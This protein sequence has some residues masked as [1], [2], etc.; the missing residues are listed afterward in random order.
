MIFDTLDNIGRYA[1]A[2]P[3]IL[4][5][6]PLIEQAAKGAELPIGRIEISGDTYANVMTYKPKSREEGK[7]ETHR[8]YFDIQIV[9]S[10]EERFFTASPE[11]LTET[12]PYNAAA[13]I[14][15]LEGEPQAEMRLSPGYFVLVWPGEPHMPGIRAGAETAKKMVVK[16]RA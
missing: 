12:S 1:G 16:L 10:G 6:Q 9:L 3:G 5:A 14:C 8:D 7:F 11:L 2:V 13:D 4:A 15:F